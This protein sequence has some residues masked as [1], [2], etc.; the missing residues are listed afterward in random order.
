[1]RKNKVTQFFIYLLACNF[2]LLLSSFVFSQTL[3]HVFEKERSFEDDVIYF[4]NGDVLRGTVRNRFF[5]VNASYGSFEIP[6]DKCAGISFDNQR[7]GF[8]IIL[9]VN[10]NRLSGYQIQNSVVFR[11]SSSGAEVNIPIQQISHLVFRSRMD[12]YTPNRFREQSN[13]YI[14]NNGDSL[15][16]ELENNMIEMITDYGDVPI[17]V[18]DITELVFPDELM[19]EVTLTRKNGD[20]ITGKV[21]NATFTIDL[22]IDIELRDV[23]QDKILKIITGVGELKKIYEQE[24]T[25]VTR[26][27]LLRN[28]KVFAE[29]KY[30]N[31]LGMT[32]CKIKPGKFNMGSPA[33]EPGRN[34][35]EKRHLVILD[36]PFFI[37]TTEVTQKQWN[38]LMPEN[39]SHFK[40]EDRPVENVSWFDA[41]VFISKL[42]AV[43]KTL[44]YRL[45]TEAEWEY[46]A[47]A[48]ADG[49][50]CFGNNRRELG[51]YAWYEE[52][53]Q[54]ETHEVASRRPN[55]W[56]LHDMHGNVREWCLDKGRWDKGVQTP[57][58]IQG[59]RN[60]VSKEGEDRVSRG[61]SF[62]FHSRFC[63]SSS[64]YCNAPGSRQD[65]VGFRL[66]GHL[67]K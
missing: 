59:V 2:I 49:M 27:D 9:T 61:G 56:G 7:K 65:S 54:G 17:P 4:R 50:Y 33:S 34:I 29:K 10:C 23:Y 45:P 19:S 31:I 38:Q 25:A 63:R 64:R 60:P 3:T 39:P 8:V 11:L 53:S 55:A 42:N 21:K 46:A 26:S 12:E 37:Q 62:G 35:H 6:S 44:L 1:M 28:K 5:N 14:M 41:Q 15:T 13:L 24:L 57:T 16:G 43:D 52:N 36:E 30:T 51:K 40:G 18:S 32:F 58:F 48:G 66:T 47:R 67:R 20:K 22:N